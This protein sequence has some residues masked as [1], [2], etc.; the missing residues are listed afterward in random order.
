MRSSVAEHSDQPELRR[1]ASGW[2]FLPLMVLVAATAS[3]PGSTLIYSGG[4]QFHTDLQGARLLGELP[5]SG[6]EPILLFSGRPTINACKQ[7]YCDPETSV[8][9]EWAS[10]GP[11]MWTSMALRYPGDYYVSESG[12]LAARVRMF[13][14]RCLDSREAAVWFIQKTANGPQQV[15]SIWFNRVAVAFVAYKNML[16]EQDLTENMPDIAVARAEVSKGV[17][18]EIPPLPKIERPAAAYVSPPHPRFRTDCSSPAPDPR[19]LPPGPGSPGKPIAYHD[20]QTDILFYVESDGRHLAALDR[21]GK[22][23]WVRDPF[24]DQNLCPYRNARPI[25]FRIGPIPKPYEALVVKAWKRQGP[26]IEIHFDSSQFGAV[27][28]K[29]GDF[30]F[31]GQN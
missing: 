6:K 30:F 24:V 19:D 5:V 26:F 14:G 12:S 2:L 7:P 16:G 3:E 17:C 4:K 8:F 25:I 1:F 23:L 21:S 15:E 27:D 10:S 18:R 22:L 11:N 20:D 13:I 31:E 9:F 29:T 28:V